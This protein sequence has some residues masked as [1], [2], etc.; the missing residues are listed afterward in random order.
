MKQIPKWSLSP[1]GGNEI[2]VINQVLIICKHSI[3]GAV[4]L[5]LHLPCGKTD[6]LVFE[7]VGYSFF[8]LLIYITSFSM[9]PLINVRIIEVSGNQEMVGVYIRN[10]NHRIA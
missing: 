4:S 3:Q 2:N 7:A 1:S 8:E 5:S 9:G 10:L 6:L